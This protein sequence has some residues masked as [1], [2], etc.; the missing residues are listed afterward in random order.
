MTPHS[1][2][3]FFLV[4]I[5]CPEIFVN[6]PEVSSGVTDAAYRGG[7]ANRRTS[8]PTDPGQPSSSQM[9]SRSMADVL[10]MQETAARVR[11]TI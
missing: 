2:A 11:H 8:R 10:T 6:C 7:S 9:E 4:E 1:R 3:N 5:Q